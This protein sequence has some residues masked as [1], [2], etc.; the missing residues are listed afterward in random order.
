MW[1]NGEAGLRFN[2]LF[3]KI[4]TRIVICMSK[5]YM[6]NEKRLFKTIQAHA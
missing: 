5:T 2:S 4:G 1:L 3:S 6:I